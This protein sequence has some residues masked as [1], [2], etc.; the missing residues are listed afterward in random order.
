MTAASVRVN[1]LRRIAA[2]L[3]GVLVLVALLFFL[4]HLTVRSSFLREVRA[5]ALT[6]ARCAIAG[7]DPSDVEAVR[8]SAD[9]SGDAYKRLQN[10][11]EKF[12]Q[13]A[14]EV[15]FVYI[16]RKSSATGA[17][18]TDFEY[19]ADLPAPKSVQGEG[20]RDEQEPPGKPYDASR[21]PA[22]LRGWSAPDADDDVSPDPPYPD[23][24]S[25]YAPIKDGSGKTVGLLG[26]DV[27]ART[28]NSK[29]LASRTVIAISGLL[30]A[31]MLSVLIFFYDA[32]KEALERIQELN[33]ELD[34]R[35]AKLLAIMRLK[36]NLS[37]MIVHD[38]RAPFSIIS[39]YSELL[40]AEGMVPENERNEILQKIKDQAKRVKSFLEDILMV[41]KSEA[42]S[43]TLT[44]HPTDLCKFMTSV[45]EHNRVVAVQSTVRIDL[46][47][48]EAPLTVSIDRDL[49]SRVMDNLITN[50]VKYSPRE[51]RVVVRLEQVEGAAN[52]CRICVSD[53]GPGISSETKRN[54]FESFATG[55]IKP[56]TGK[57]FGIGLFFCKMAVEAHGGSIGIE[58]NAPKGSVFI[59]EIYDVPVG[60]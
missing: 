38:M 11:L 24:M 29:L 10:H 14:P 31:I 56:S 51:G 25:A 8:S 21:F 13:V 27:T 17:K 34:E 49:F 40:L 7:V 59:V 36:D 39:G 28:I 20:G 33:R 1:R 26:V 37:R 55:E 44:R 50:A 54:L 16:M 43:L 48:P 30:L 4:L 46:E 35:N 3:V 58:D 22:L 57:Q 47:L 15:R 52:R 18:D 19:V 5:Y 41:A 9:V 6:F 32:R 60:G 42:G 45:V 23:L 12:R 53:C 2:P